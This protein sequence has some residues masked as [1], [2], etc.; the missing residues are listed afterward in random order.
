MLNYDQLKA[1]PRDFLAVTGLTPAAYE[2]LLPACIAAYPKGYPATHTL[3]GQPRQRQAGAGAKGKLTQW[4][5][6]LLFILIY[7]QTNPR[8]T[9]HDL[10]FQLSQ[11]QANM[12][13]HRLLPVRQQAL[14]DL[15]QALGQALA[16]PRSAR[17]RRWP[18]TRCRTRGR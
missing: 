7:T 3:H 13:M 9:L 17:R 12:W 2:H 10:Q 1:R 6:K 16:K 8:Q 11:G 15:G 4:S 18:R 14:R 5:D